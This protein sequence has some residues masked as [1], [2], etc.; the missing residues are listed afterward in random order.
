MSTPP[1]QAHVRITMST[2]LPANHIARAI[3]RRAHASVLLCAL[4]MVGLSAAG[5]CR[6]ERSDAPP[7][8]FLPDLDDQP[9]WKAQSKSEFY[10]DGRSMR[11]PVAGTVAFGRAPDAADPR[12]ADFLREDKAHYQGKDAK[13]EFLDTIPMEVTEAM[14]RRGQDR[15]NIYCSACHGYEGDGKGR[16]GAMWSYPLP[17][18]YDPKYADKKE[19]TGK[20]GYVF[21]VTRYGVVDATGAQKMPGYAHALDV[22]DSWAIVSY[23]RALQAS[24]LGT[25][26][27]VPESERAALEQKRVTA[28][29]AAPAKPA[30]PAV[31]NAPKDNASTEKRQ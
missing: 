22:D 21:N 2:Q 8:Q 15:F 1:D 30:T 28:P 20:D 17:T 25:I 4:G 29:P 11:Q 5:G 3:A 9:R 12:R 26:Q 24:R 13:G 16:V 31:P 18:F 7:H 14:I 10:A 27:D 6:G 23:V 19:R